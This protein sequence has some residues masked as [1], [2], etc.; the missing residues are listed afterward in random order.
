MTD[1]RYQFPAA[2]AE[3]GRRHAVVEA[4][5]GT[6]KTYL[7]EHLVVDL[8]VR[9]G[10]EL[11]QILVV[12]FTEKATAELQHRVRAKLA[13]LVALR[14]GDRAAE[15]AN[16]ADPASTW[17]I[18]QAARE[19][20]RRALR[21][22][23]RASIS[24]IHAFCQRVLATHAFANGRLFAEEQVEEADAFHAA[25]VESLRHDVA[26]DA[27]AAELLAAYRAQAQPLDALEGTMM[28]LHAR[29]S[30]LHPPRPQALRIPT[31][32]AAGWRRLQDAWPDEASL[33]CL[34]AALKR[35]GRH[36]RTANMM[37][38]RLCELGRLM[39][40]QPGFRLSDVLTRLADAEDARKYLRE[41]LDEAPVG[42]DP[43]V[44]TVVAAFHELDRLGRCGLQGALVDRLLPKVRARLERR[45]REQ[46]LFDFQDMLTLV[47]RAVDDEGP[48]GRAL[49]GALRGQH[50]HALVD[51]AQDTDDVQW[52]IFRRVFLDSPQDHVLTLVGDPKQAIYS[53]RG[54]DVH[55][56]L[57]AREQIRERGGA[58]VHLTENH[59]STEP[60]VRGY[61]A[62][63]DQDAA[64]PFFRTDG[65]IQY[66]H[67]VACGRP[68]QR[69]VH[70]D[71]SPAPAMV[72]LDV[73]PS[74]DKPKAWQVRA[75]VLHGIVAELRRMLDP[76]G[77]LML[78]DGRRSRRLGPGDVFVLT[79]KN[80]ESREVGEAL[81]AARIPFAFYKQE[82]LF[83]TVEARQVLDLLRALADPDDR[84]ARARALI[85]PFFDLALP[86]LAACNDLPPEHP[87]RAR[88]AG[89]T[90]LANAADFERLFAR[91]VDDSGVVC[92][93]I[94]VGRGERAL[95]NYMHLFELLQG[96]A[97]RGRASIRELAQ[98]LGSWVRGTRRPAG[99]ESDVQRLE[100]DEEAVQ[101]MTIHHSKGLEAPVVFLYGG[102]SDAPPTNVYPFHDETGARVVDLGVPSL[103]DRRRYDDEQRDEER[104]VYYVA[105]TRA[106]GRLVLPRYPTSFRGR[107]AYLMVDARLRALF[108]AGVPPGLADDVVRREL[109]CPPPPGAEPPTL[110]PALAGWNPDPA[111]L[112]PAAR[113]PGFRAAAT[114]RSGFLMT[115]YSAVKRAH[116]A[117]PELDAAVADDPAAGDAMT[118]GAAAAA[119]DLPPGRLSGTFL[120]EL[121]ELVPLEPLA[122]LPSLPDWSR[123]TDVRDLLARSARRHD[124]EPRHL[125][126][127]ARLVHTAW[128]SPVALGDAP[129][130]AGLA[131]AAACRREVE[132]LFPIPERLQPLL[133]RAPTAGSPDAAPFRIERG[134][135]K[136]FIDLLFN[137]HGRTYVCDWKGDALP[138]FDPVRLRAH[139][140]R[141]Y[142]VQA[143][144]YTIAALRLLD[145]RD[146]ADYERRFGGVLF[147]FLR[148]MDATVASGT[149]THFHRPSW[150]EV[151][152]WQGAMLEDRFWG[153]S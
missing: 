44:Q 43:L 151:L 35:A 127:A 2:M 20:L 28:R 91:I 114:D 145:V 18:D 139:C 1:V 64:P 51:E 5:A 122:S 153:L 19:R 16:R 144:L 59:R 8:V 10:I 52:S 106:Q 48:E 146:P 112:R 4:S 124:R 100:T 148:G 137:H 9:A 131:T 78:D 105:L 111:L 99:Q 37:H 119:D 130:I 57:T 121:L 22:F 65:P 86:D 15:Q 126:H 104:R 98:R 66:D 70:A 73:D 54:A 110:A 128:V 23:D 61:N 3:L 7:L 63:L 72:V 6:G 24:T 89:W 21:S 147:C 14:P 49:V 97:G 102:L 12:T 141:H 38:Q 96:E 42:D 47:A 95:T 60:L 75:S 125:A 133:G 129:T 62:L 56:Y 55:T 92:R 107:G 101:I 83:E 149:G 27:D 40:S 90:A 103:A 115:S 85:T 46:G 88:L 87:I 113:D 69:L 134:V 84:T 77:G 120:H 67:P 25:F 79:R 136:G 36:P 45:K 118:T 31:V 26:S 108:D 11:E 109:P 150:A 135:V 143:R 17:L 116:S 80:W 81:R 117:V 74:A 58:V 138:D 140:L 68:E 123:R 13:E 29:L 94:F 132:F 53:F 34:P 39:R 93:E 76:Q 50:R 142:D 71:G 33:G 30:A 32:D 82:R 41:K 152:A